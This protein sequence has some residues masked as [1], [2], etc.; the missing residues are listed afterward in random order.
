MS[1]N[2]QAHAIFKAH[3]GITLEETSKS[4]STPRKLGRVFSGAK[5]LIGNEEH[6]GRGY[7]GFGQSV[8]A[9]DAD[10]STMQMISRW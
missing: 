2:K 1:L 3:Y 8:S 10:K 4:Y 7:V 9:E 6:Y 5:T